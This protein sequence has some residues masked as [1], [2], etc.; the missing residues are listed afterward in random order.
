MVFC[1]FSTVQQ[2][3]PV[4]HTYIH[5]FSHIIMLHHKWLEIVPSA[6]QQDLIVITV[7]SLLTLEEDFSQVHH[8]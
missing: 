6:I 3:D 4:L 1:Q 8:L 2:G 7:N 5:S